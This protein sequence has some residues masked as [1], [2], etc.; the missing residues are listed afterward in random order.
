MWELQR[1][2]FCFDKENSNDKGRLRIKCAKS[3]DSKF[4]FTERFGVEIDD[5]TRLEP[6]LNDLQSLFIK[7]MKSSTECK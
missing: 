4:P 5:C 3:Y 6:E 1:S 7:T 2:W